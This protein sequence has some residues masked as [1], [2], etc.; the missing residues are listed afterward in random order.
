MLREIKSHQPISRAQIARN[1]GL[2]KSTVSNIV[3]DLVARKVVLH[4]GER[5]ANGSGGRPAPEFGFNPKS[6]YGLGID[7][8]GTK[9][10]ILITDLL[11][12]VAGSRRFETTNS[13]PRIVEMA[14]EVLAESGIPEQAILALGVGV[15]GTVNSGVVLRA[16]ALSWTNYDLYSALRE[17]FSFPIFI[18]NDVN[19]AALGERWL[20]SGEFS[21]ELFFISL[22][23]GIGSAIVTNGNI[24]YGANQRAGEISYTVNRSDLDSGN[25]NILGQHGVLERRISGYALSQHGCE[26]KE[27][28]QRY[29]EGEPKAVRVIE[30]MVADLSV[31]ISNVVSLLNPSTVVIGGGIAESLDVVLDRIRETVAGLT[32]IPTTIRLASLGTLAGAYGAVAF[33][34]EQIELG[35]VEIGAST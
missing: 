23:T 8:G 26:P 28:F 5:S 34:I 3:E 21:D 20:G 2:G 25:L 14:R 32:P 22:G 29:S 35:D 12:E 27:L 10:Q 1:L 24:V 15:P 13:V 7:I 4:L 6:G 11:G 17:H 16:K 30:D 9:I 18:N 31:L 19:N 33:A